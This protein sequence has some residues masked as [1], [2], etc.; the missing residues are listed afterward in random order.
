MPPLNTLLLLLQFTLIPERMLC[1]RFWVG[2][3]S[4]GA[5][6]AL[7]YEL[8]LRPGTT[9]VTYLSTPRVFTHATLRT[10]M[11]PVHFRMRPAGAFS[12]D[13]RNLWLKE[14]CPNV[15]FMWEAGVC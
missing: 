8:L 1:R 2:P 6:A 3:L 4:G 5:F 9:K 12:G 15:R 7:V 11:T 13:D 10:S 14:H